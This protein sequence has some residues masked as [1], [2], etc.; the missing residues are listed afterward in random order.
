MTSLQK[1]LDIWN[2]PRPNQYGQTKDQMIIS[3]NETLRFIGTDFDALEKKIRQQLLVL[4]TMEK[5][6][7]N[8]EEINGEIVSAHLST[9]IATWTNHLNNLL[10]LIKLVKN[11]MKA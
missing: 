10:K 6:I 9:R 5:Y 4:N 8:W 7:D 11:Q 3:I 2:E 1:I